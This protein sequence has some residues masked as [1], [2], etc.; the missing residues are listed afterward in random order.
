[1][2]IL[3]IDTSGLTATVALSE[4]DRLVASFSI[5][6]KTTHSQILMP[7]LEKIKELTNLDLKTID[8]IA[9]AAGPGSFTGLRIGTATAKGLC[10][11]LGVPLIA[12]PTMDAMA[13]NLYGVERLICPMM[14]ARRSQVYTGVYTFVPEKSEDTSLYKYSMKTILDQKCASIDEIAG[15][16]N[17]QGKPVTILGDGVP[18]YLDA[19]EKKLKVPFSV[20]S[21]SQDRQ[22]AAALCAVAAQYMREGKT[23]DADS[24]A[25]EYLRVSQAERTSLKK[26][27]EGDSS[28]LSKDSA[29]EQGRQEESDGG[30]FG[31]KIPKVKERVFIRLMKAEDIDMAAALEKENLGTEAWTLDQLLTASTRD[32]TIYLVAE[33]KDRII[34]LCGVQNIQGD[35]E[36]TNV[37]VSKDMRG[38][39]VGYKMMR[40]LLERGRGIGIDNYTMEVRSQN[41]AARKLYEKLGFKSDGTRPGFYDNPKDDAEIYWLRKKSEN[42]N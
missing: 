5:Q 32:D 10:L 41:T 31:M 21:V 18:V 8:A 16:L 24:F 33:K 34:G 25:P 15:Y 3:A 13:Y 36:I 27:S 7:M 28:S 9:L 17:E 19:L 6:Y 4:D 22:N 2:K 30:S 29:S 14:D 37:S 42:E 1:L 35:G 23:T 26:E 11:A 39:G 20:A 12:V 38:E 40:Q